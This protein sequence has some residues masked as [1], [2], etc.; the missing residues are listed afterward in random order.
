MGNNQETTNFNTHRFVRKLNDA[1]VKEQYQVK[2]WSRFADMENLDD[3]VD[4][5]TAGDSGRVMVCKA[6]LFWGPIRPP[7]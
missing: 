5:S 7:K 3:N 1:E 4:I 2:I 6:A